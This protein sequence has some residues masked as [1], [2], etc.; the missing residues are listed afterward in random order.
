MNMLSII[1]KNSN[2][3]YNV[4]FVIM[5]YILSIHMLTT[6][7]NLSNLINKLVILHK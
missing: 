5:H 3:S 6:V 2:T 4:L 1:L 7:T